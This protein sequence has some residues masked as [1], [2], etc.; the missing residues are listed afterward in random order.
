MIKQILIPLG[1]VALF[2]IIV[3]VLTRNPATF[4]L[5]EENKQKSVT[6]EGHKIN[7]E[8]AS[9]DAQR[10]QGLGDRKEL[11]ENSGM[12]FVF[13]TQNVRPIFWMRLERE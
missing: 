1:V 12:L 6:I 3:G 13:D 4:G 7:L 10:Q 2:I 11:P 5:G 8:V 9:T